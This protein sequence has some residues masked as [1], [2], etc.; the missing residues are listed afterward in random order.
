[1]TTLIVGGDRINTYK[2][3]LDT[4]GY[5][6]ILHWNGRN[7]SECHRKIP[8]RTRLVVIMVDQ[9]NHRLAI[10]MREVAHRQNLPVIF[11]K[12]SIAQLAR[13]IAHHR[14][15]GMATGVQ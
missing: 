8:S 9:I 5:G 15:A 13:A 7:N 3:Y 10:K 11:S 1:M 2:E 12:R 4:N 14:N 6:P